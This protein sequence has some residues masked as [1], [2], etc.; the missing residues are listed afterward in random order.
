MKVIEEQESSEDD[1]YRVDCSE[2][3][4]IENVEDD[5]EESL[6]GEEEEI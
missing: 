5:C 4:N 3:K 1:G 6:E 2:D